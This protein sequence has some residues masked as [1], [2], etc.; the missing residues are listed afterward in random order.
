[1]KD[2]LV[3]LGNKNDQ[4]IDFEEQQK[5]YKEKRESAEKFAREQAKELI[6]FLKGRNLSYEEAEQIVDKFMNMTSSELRFAREMM[7]E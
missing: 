4:E 3:E 7:E 2:V 1:M 5:E 6:T